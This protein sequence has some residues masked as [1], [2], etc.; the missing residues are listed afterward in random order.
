MNGESGKECVAFYCP[1]CTTALQSR[2]DRISLDDLFALWKE[3]DFK[4]ET[5]REHRQQSEFT[6]L[7]QCPSCELEIYLPQIIGM[8]CFYEDLQKAPYYV[9]EKWEFKEALADVE[10]S[11]SII[12]IGCGPGNF[13]EKVRT[14][15]RETCGFEYNDRAIEIASKKGFSVLSTEDDIRLNKGRFDAAFSFHVIEHVADPV[16]FL[17]TICSLVKDGG[18]IGISVPNME[19]P[20]KYIEP[21]VSNMPP[22]HA[23]RWRVTTLRTLAKRLGLTME[24]VAYEPLR[25]SNA[26]Y[27]SKYWVNQMLPA[28]SLLNATVRFAASLFFFISFK[29]IALFNKKGFSLFKGQ[30]IYVL[31]SK[32]TSCGK[33]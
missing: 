29:L 9:D 2:S 25:Y 26:D 19:G 33:H 22:H 27:Y 32:R 23:T 6:K 30:S 31:M 18:R 11:D 7:Y 20:I 13:L 17:Q 10:K 12:E 3:I 5:I 14:C 4:E 28:D 21:C 8:P 1:I 15:V 16:A 24:R